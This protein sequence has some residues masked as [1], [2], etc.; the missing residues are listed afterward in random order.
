MKPFFAALLYVGLVAITSPVR[1]QYELSAQPLTQPYTLT[2]F[3]EPGEVEQVSVDF[4]AVAAAAH[5]S[6]F[7]LEVTTPTETIA[8]DLQRVN[9]RSAT[10]ERTFASG[11]VDHRQL[12]SVQYQ[13]SVAGTPAERANFTFDQHFLLGHW[14]VAGR[15]WVLEP[16]WL[17]QPGAPQD[18]Y[19]LFRADN[20]KARAAY[21]DVS[22]DEITMPGSG[23]NGGPWIG[24]REI[25]LAVAVDSL[26]Y[27][28]FPSAESV[29]NFLLGIL[30]LV[31]GDYDL[32]FSGNLYFTLSSL[33]LSDGF[34]PEAWSGETEAESLIR[35]FRDWGNTNDWAGTFDMATFWTGRDLSSASSGN[36][37][38]GYAFLRGACG[39]R[40]YQIVERW[41]WDSSSLR[42]IWSHE[43]GHSFGAE[44]ILGQTLI[45]SA[46]LGP[47]NRT[48]SVRTQNRIRGNL[49]FFECLETSPWVAFQGRGEGQTAVLS[50]FYRHSPENEGFTVQRA[51]DDN[52]PWESRG[53]VAANSAVN[54]SGYEFTDEGLRPGEVYFYRLLQEDTNGETF[55]TPMVRV[56]VNYFNATRISPNPA[57]DIIRIVSADNRPYDYRITNVEGKIV[58]SGEA[59]LGATEVDLTG[60]A[61]GLYLYYEM[62]DNNFRLVTKFIKR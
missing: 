45:M 42:A 32:G 29:E 40:R 2:Q 53:W 44:H 61:S 62:T 10:F 33:Y 1:A 49:P 15:D 39:E 18:V 57:T 12:P 3:Q 7:S 6:S 37:N 34:T 47:Q 26:M 46:N 35:E 36:N 13:G 31:Q 17:T 38:I 11:R 28:Q 24:A 56:V 20:L 9:L 48:W 19:L 50:W 52:G 25:E 27:Q 41:T 43:I 23:R 59:L 21:C 58:R 4:A 16:L 51:R 5:G 8:F 22:T 55:I 30:A 60:M 14:T 54:S